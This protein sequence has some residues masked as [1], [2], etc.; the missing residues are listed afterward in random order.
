MINLKEQ[1]LLCRVWAFTHMLDNLTDKEQALYPQVAASLSGKKEIELD[2]QAMQE[3]FWPLTE[4]MCRRLINK[5][6]YETKGKRFIII[7]GSE[8]FKTT[9]AL[10]AA[11]IQKRAAGEVD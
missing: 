1:P 10:R 7:N 5:F 2:I 11:Y 4:A 6:E 9:D 8:I 3:R